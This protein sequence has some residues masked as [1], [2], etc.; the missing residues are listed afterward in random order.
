MSYYGDLIK[1]RSTLVAYDSRIDTSRHIE[2]VAGY[3]KDVIGDL[4][5]RAA[6]HDSSK[7]ESPE[8]E[9]FDI[10]TPR[11]R[12]L[13]YDSPEYKECLVE[14]GT[15]LQHHYNHNSHHPE[16]FSNGINGMSLLDIIEMLCDW[17]AAGERVKDGSITNSIHANRE[18][19][20]IDAQLYNILLNTAIEMGWVGRDH[21]PP[22]V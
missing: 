16:H 10:F 5:Y 17:K 9:M 14:M 3:L 22:S 15:A 18:R 20:G 21:A 13:P 7:L 11:L 2:R 19:F 6:I 4:G 12:Q 8:R 1:I